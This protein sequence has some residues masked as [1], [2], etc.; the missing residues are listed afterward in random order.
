E[1]S[2]MNT[3]SSVAHTSIGIVGDATPGGWDVDT[4]M[5][6]NP[7]NPYLW[8]KIITLTEADVKFRANDA[9][10]I[11]WGSPAFP[12]GIGTLGGSNIAVKAGTYFVT[13]NTGT[14]E[15]YFLK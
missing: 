7:A 15:Y 1:Y 6:R 13:F 4:D 12:M 11:N 5:I 8:S 2:F 14:G 10:D 3:A 9:W